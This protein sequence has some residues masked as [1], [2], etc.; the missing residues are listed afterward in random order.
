MQLPV[1]LQK[2]EGLAHSHECKMIAYSFAICQKLT[3]FN[4]LAKILDSRWQ[5]QYA[6]F[7]TRWCGVLFFLFFQ[8]IVISMLKS[9]S[10]Q[11]HWKVDEI[12]KKKN[13]QRFCE[14]L[15]LGV[16]KVLKI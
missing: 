6:G 9:S 4:Y 7:Q 10:R 13:K 3:I 15:F 1:R 8:C 11:G 12:D 14:Q 16:N 5:N 2:L